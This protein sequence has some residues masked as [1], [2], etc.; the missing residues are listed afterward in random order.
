MIWDILFET[1]IRT[2]WIAI[3]ILPLLLIVEWANHKYG[4]KLIDFFERRKKFM[5]LWAALLAVLPGCNVAAAVALLY[6]KK[7]VSM[8]ALVA[9]MIATS[10]EAIYAFIPQRF[11]FLPLFGVKLILAI[12][13]GFMVDLFVNKVV[14]KN[15]GG[16]FKVGYCCSIHEHVH[17]FREM[18]IHVLKHGVKII[19][20]IFIV[21]FSFNLVKD[22]YGFDRI[23]G[24]ILLGR[25]LQPAMAAFIGL[26]PGCGTSVVLATLYTQGI[27]TF[28]GAVSGLAVASGDT[29][30]VLMS[31]KV[32]KKEIYTIVSIVLLV[33]I[34]A[35]YAI[36]YLKIPPFFINIL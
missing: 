29:L 34:M 20:F 17:S 26:I 30:L 16:G 36:N 1:L 35:G 5:P 28:G 27:L 4:E 8:G 9:A 18:V 11:N 32:P 3:V 15:K 10:D 31:N 33:G 24:S 22:I 25:G 7:L 6:A 13:T 23:A 2:F 12:I 19:F 21:L 14:R